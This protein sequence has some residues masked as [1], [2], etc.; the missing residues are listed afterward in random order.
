MDMAKQRKDEDDLF[1]NGKLGDW[2]FVEKP[3]QS[4]LFFLR[5][6][7]HGMPDGD[8]VMLPLSGGKGPIWQWDGNR[9]VPT[10]SPSIRVCDSDGERWHGFFRNGKLETV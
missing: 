6:P 8:V 3:N 7:V 10:I 9:D 5:Y 4:L 1:K 2:C